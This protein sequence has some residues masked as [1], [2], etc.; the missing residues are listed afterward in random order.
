MGEAVMATP[1]IAD[2]TLFVRVHSA[3][4]AVGK[5]KK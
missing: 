5:T 1:A 2:G 3:L 4:Y